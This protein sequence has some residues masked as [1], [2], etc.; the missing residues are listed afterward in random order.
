MRQPPDTLDEQ[1]A[2]RAPARALAS[3]STHGQLA[4]VAWVALKLGCLAFGGPA[5]HIA[6]LHDEVVV[7]RRWLSE[8]EF[9][10]LLG[11][12]NLIPGP[13][14]TEMVI[15][16][17]YRRAGWPGL[18]VGGTLFILPAALIVLALAW[19]YVRWG[20]LPQAIWLL[21]GVMPV[22][23]AVVAQAI[24]TLGRSAVRRPV[25]IALAV[26]VFALY[27]W[28]IHELVLLAA[29]A[30]TMLLIATLRR[31]RALAL[32]LAPVGLAGLGALPTTAGVPVSLAQLFLTFLKIGAVLYGSGYVLLA[33]LRRDFVERLGWLT[34]RQ[35]LDA[36]AVGQVTP[37]PVFTTATFVGYL[38][39][40]LPGAVLA[41]IGIFLPAFVFVA[42]VR[43]F[44][45]RLRRSPWTAPFLDGLNVAA[46][47]LMAGVLW[48][49]G[50]TVLVDPLSLLLA[51]GALIAL[52]RF[53]INSAWLVLA[54]G[55]IGILVQLP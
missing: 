49:I 17:S 26:A 46:L 12:T 37:G 53:R 7:R 44:V 25:Q 11:V 55:A 52:V 22:I 27:L 45:P 2:T 8:Q 14:S 21:D 34:D 41:T 29:A 13:N 23:I 18:V 1:A 54:G 16:C 3:D 9:L 30:A 31:G 33:F 40:G 32:G 38:V 20:T 36:I 15:H 6:M 50:R 24:W 19:L 35:L 47:A 4:E 48:Q 5:A 43:P 28:G 10:D 39:A 42:A 51:L